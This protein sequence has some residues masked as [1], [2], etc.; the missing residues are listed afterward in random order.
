MAPKSLGPATAGALLSLK[1][2][3][4]MSRARWRALPWVTGSLLLVVAAL[5]CEDQKVERTNPHDPKAWGSIA[6]RVEFAGEGRV[7]R[8]EVCLRSG[9]QVLSCMR[10]TAVGATLPFSFEPVPPGSY[11]LEAVALGYAMASMSITL[12][13]QEHLRDLVVSPQVNVGIVLGRVQRRDLLRD[14]LTSSDISVN[15]EQQQPSGSA[16]PIG[17]DVELDSDGRFEQTLRPGSYRLDANSIGYDDASEPF[18]V[19]QGETSTVELVLENAQPVAEPIIVSPPGLTNSRQISITLSHPNSAATLEL[20][21]QDENPESQVERVERQPAP[22]LDADNATGRSYAVFA[23]TLS[24][25]DG[26]KAI[27]A[28]ARGPAGNRSSEVATRLELD[29]M[30]PDPGQLIVAGGAPSVRRQQLEAILDGAQDA[31][32]I[33]YRVIHGDDFERCLPL[34]P[35]RPATGVLVVD[36]LPER[37]AQWICWAVADRAGNIRQGMPQSITLGP[38]VQR[39]TPRVD[40][41]SPDRLVARPSGEPQLTIVG[42]GL[43]GDTVADVGSQ[44]SLPCTFDRPADD[45]ALNNPSAC[46]TTCTII[47]PDEIRL[48]PDQYLVTLRTPEPVAG[49]AGISRELRWLNVVSPEQLYVD[50]VDPQGFALTPDGPTEVQITIEG[51]DILGA[52]E[53]SLALRPPVSLEVERPDP[54]DPDAVKLIATFDLEGIVPSHA[55]PVE[56]TIGNPGVQPTRL[57]FSVVAQQ[58]CELGTCRLRSR[59]TYPPGRPGHVA[60]VMALPEEG[61][62]DDYAVGGASAWT[63]RGP[64]GASLLGWKTPYQTARLSWPLPQP[65]GRM[66]AEAPIGS[67]EPIEISPGDF[68]DPDGACVY[69]VVERLSRGTYAEAVVDLDGSGH[70]RGVFLNEGQGLIY[71]SLRPDLP[72]IVDGRPGL[73]RA[74]DVNGDGLAD[75]LVSDTLTN[76]ISAWLGAG[77]GTF[78]VEWRL[79]PPPSDQISGDIEELVVTDVDGDRR[80]DIIAGVSG[81]SGGVL[82]WV[83]TPDGRS[84]SPEIIMSDLSVFTLSAREGHHPGLPEIFFNGDVDG[85]RQLWTWSPNHGPRQLGEGFWGDSREWLDVVGRDGAGT[86]QLWASEA[87]IG[88]RHLAQRPGGE[89]RRIV[90]GQVHETTRVSPLQVVDL[91]GDG[92]ASVLGVGIGG[93]ATLQAVDLTGGHR[94]LGTIPTFP[95]RWAARLTPHLQ[96]AFSSHDGLSRGN[97]YE[98]SD[99]PSPAA[100]QR[101]VGRP[102]VE[103]LG[104]PLVTG[105]YGWVD[106]DGDGLDDAIVQDGHAIH[107]IFGPCTTAAC[108]P[109]EAEAHD[110]TSLAVTSSVDGSPMLVIGRTD[111]VQMHQVRAD[112]SMGR[113]VFSHHLP[114]G[115][116]VVHPLRVGDRLAIAALA[117]RHI[118]IVGPGSEPARLRVGDQQLKRILT[119]QLRADQ[120]PTLVAETNG[121]LVLW[122]SDGDQWHRRG[123]VSWDMFGDPDS[124]RRPFTWTVADLNQGQ[125]PELI[126]VGRGASHV[127]VYGTQPQQPLFTE[128]RHRSYQIFPGGEYARGEAPIVLHSADVNLDGFIDIIVGSPRLEVL[129]SDGAGGGLNSADIA[130]FLG[131]GDGTLADNAIL[132]PCQAP[133]AGD[134]DL[135]TVTLSTAELTGDGL[136]EIVFTAGSQRC[137]RS[138]AS[139][140]STMLSSVVETDLTRG[141]GDQPTA[142]INHIGAIYESVTLIATVGADGAAEPVAGTLTSPRGDISRLAPARP[143]DGVVS[144]SSVDDDALYALRGRQPTGRWIVDLDNAA[145]AVRSV[146]LL[147]GVRWRSANAPSE[148]PRCEVADAMVCDGARPTRAPGPPGDCDEDGIPDLADPCPTTA[149]WPNNADADCGEPT[150]PECARDCEAFCARDAAC[151]LGDPSDCSRRCAESPAGCANCVG[152]ATCDEIAHGACLAVCTVDAAE[153]VGGGDSVVEGCTR[154]S[155]CLYDCQGRGCG[156]D[157][158]DNAKPRSR[159]AYT[160]V[161]RCL[162]NNSCHGNLWA[163]VDCIRG[164]C[165]PEVDACYGAPREP[166]GDATCT[167]E[168]NCLSRCAGPFDLGCQRGCVESTAPASHALM[169]ALDACWS[170]D[171]GDDS[172]CQRECAGIARACTMDGVEPGDRSCADGIECIVECI[173]QPG[174]CDSACLDGLSVESGHALAA[175]SRCASNSGCRD[176]FACESCVDLLGV[177]EEQ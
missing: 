118:D 96:V 21:T 68:G 87:Y 113:K 69:Q 83:V 144:W 71:T 161:S 59:R 66:V 61:A 128:R 109:V 57:P 99:C 40:Q 156:P 132:L 51:R 163:D 95:D 170:A 2:R 177:C 12:T 5:G 76:R 10:D 27:V 79:P 28:V 92:Q 137:V 134:A 94:V 121:G 32:Y 37:G 24:E 25:G 34:T 148:A 49:S 116:R 146:E 152:A 143:V 124:V 93:P 157:C 141:A 167:A 82:R 142:A 175:L 122:N 19:K 90:Q 101:G 20:L 9:D 35:D 149:Q 151:A 98:A 88:R 115:V 171:C 165:Q 70:S 55:N 56:L 110:L 13:T 103:L 117:E 39:P 43:A 75:L 78:P 72:L 18:E 127:E 97:Y 60:I 47:L 155:R 81:Q 46:A 29:T 22:S 48:R 54:A 108:A 106:V 154:L 16:T 153:D 52:A 80:P 129:T 58:P 33:G 162:N 38:Y 50:R 3:H 150:H 169:E 104:H 67:A 86:L 14:E 100:H 168:T 164:A 107:T 114:D 91:D 119:P 84:A 6:G 140:E 44:T 36:L 133:L 42:A 89:W 7:D 135:A 139:V 45:C 64:D 173:S 123:E 62:A 26:D 166:V 159:D 63:L 15:L 111:R 4:A 31:D 8:P 1:W 174:G 85:E 158:Y 11:T 126:V 125:E 17:L 74:G 120:P 41:I 112:G 77:D 23:V 105:R 138:L 53:L 136:P 176:V 145:P 30:P 131:L 65:A 172:E 130:V 73:V 147:V 102:A 160:R